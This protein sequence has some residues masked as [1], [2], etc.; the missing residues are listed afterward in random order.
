MIQSLSPMTLSGVKRGVM[1]VSSKLR[2]IVIFMIFNMT[3]IKLFRLFCFV[4][5]HRFDHTQT[6][7]RTVFHKGICG[8]AQSMSVPLGGFLST[9][10]AV[11]VAEPPDAPPTFIL[12]IIDWV[13][14]NASVI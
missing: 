4:W 11:P 10:P 13:H 5:K 7:L 9:A 8:M 12:A 2:G 3:A 14:N 6:T 1:A